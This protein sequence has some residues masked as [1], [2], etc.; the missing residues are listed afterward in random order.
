[1]LF[2]TLTDSGGISAIVNAVGSSRDSAVDAAAVAM[3]CDLTTED[4][5]C[6][7]ALFEALLRLQRP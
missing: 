7:H 6:A 2:R 3:L 1:M 5:V 4:N